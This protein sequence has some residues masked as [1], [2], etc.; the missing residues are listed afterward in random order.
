LVNRL[1]DIARERNCIAI[2]LWCADDLE[3]NGF[4]QAMGFHFGGQREGGQKRGRNAQQMGAARDRR[5]ST[6][7]CS[8]RQHESVARRGCHIRPR[9]T[10]Q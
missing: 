5:R 6:P 1:I 9:S 7:A 4:W 3:S 8:E 2:S 10:Q